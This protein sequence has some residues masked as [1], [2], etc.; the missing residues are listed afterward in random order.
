MATKGPSNHYGNARHG[1]KGH[2]TTHIGYAW[3]KKFDKS[4]VRIHIEKHGQQY[5]EARYIAKAITFANR[6]DRMYH[7]SYVRKDGTT[8]KY[9]HKT[10]EFVVVDKN[11]TVKTYYQPK[12]GFLE[13]L[14][15]RRNHK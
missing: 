9:S 11:G 4:T 5:G 13:Y 7:V 2:V 15:D 14:K 6:I 12:L 3:A 1:K 10:N 8:V